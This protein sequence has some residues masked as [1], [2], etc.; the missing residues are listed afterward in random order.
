MARNQDQDS[1]LRRIGDLDSLQEVDEDGGKEPIQESTD[2]HEV[3]PAS[4]STVESQCLSPS[5]KTSEYSTVFLLKI[6]K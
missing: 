2:M 5:R 4:Q 3:L 1:S 6:Y